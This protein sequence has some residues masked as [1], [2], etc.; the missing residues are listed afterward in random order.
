MIPRILHRTVPADT[1]DQVEEWW[2]HA[3]DLHPDWQHRTWRD[4]LNASEFPLTAPAWNLCGTGA[5]F[6]GLIRLEA[7]WHHGGIY[8]DADVEMYRPLTSLLELPAF[9]AWEDA[10]TVP[11]AV[12]GA[13]PHHPAVGE[14]IDEAL[15]RLRSGSDDWRTGNGA[16]STGPGVFTTLL[17]GRDDVLLLPPGAFYEI[18]YT[19]KSDLDRPAVPYEFARHHWHASWLGE[20]AR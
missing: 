19:A 3:R 15:A 4:P 18:H 12:F 2:R 20:E 8:L 17:P 7:I 1:S 14:M 6:A 9:A 16:W 10:Q 13:E 5:Q 11:D